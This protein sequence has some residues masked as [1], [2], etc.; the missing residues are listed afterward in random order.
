MK[1]CMVSNFSNCEDS[2]NVTVMHCYGYNVAYMKEIND[3]GRVCI[4]RYHTYYKKLI[5]QNEF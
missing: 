3:C 2:W 5:E 4:G 1:A